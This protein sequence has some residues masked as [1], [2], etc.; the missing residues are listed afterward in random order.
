MERGIGYIREA[1]PLFDSLYSG[2]VIK[3]VLEG[4]FNSGSP[5]K[6]TFRGA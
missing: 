4:R 2:T 1:K 6:R 5:Q 3:G